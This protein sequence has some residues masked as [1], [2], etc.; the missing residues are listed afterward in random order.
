[1]HN[2]IH[3]CITANAYFIEQMTLYCVNL[4]VLIVCH[5]VCAS[6][7]FVMIRYKNN[8]NPQAARQ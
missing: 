4:I 7:L 1:M 2:N 3:T 8:M 5:C 6:A